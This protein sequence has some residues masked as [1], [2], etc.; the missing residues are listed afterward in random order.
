MNKII[1]KKEVQI[2]IIEFFIKT[3]VPRMQKERK[4]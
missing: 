3:S 1:L 4:D 2:K